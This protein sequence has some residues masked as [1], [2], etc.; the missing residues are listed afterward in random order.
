VVFPRAF[1]LSSLVH[2]TPLVVSRPIVV[3]PLKENPDPL[4]PGVK[5]SEAQRLSREQPRNPALRGS[6]RLGRTGH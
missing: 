4:G 2:F 1:S 3:A 5:D 6:R